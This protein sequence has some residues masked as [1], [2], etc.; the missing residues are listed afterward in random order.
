[1]GHFTDSEKAWHVQVFA[2][3]ARIPE[4]KA[5]AELFEEVCNGVDNVMDFAM[6]LDI[7]SPEV[8][9]NGLR[10]PR[11]SMKTSDPVFLIVRN[12]CEKRV[13]ITIEHEVDLLFAV[14]LSTVNQLLQ[15]R[16]L[17]KQ[18]HTCSQSLSLSIE[19][20][21]HITYCVKNT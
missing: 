10:Y 17:S 16:I 18:R 3:L 8:G 6:H 4:G 19:C 13:A 15:V 5:V 11:Q 7:E 2:Q 12:D 21:M 14:P 20:P 1:M 9:G